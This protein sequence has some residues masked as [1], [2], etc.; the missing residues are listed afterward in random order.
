MRESGR[1]S[2]VITAQDLY[3][4]TKCA[5]RVYLDAHGEASERASVSPFVELLWEMGMQTERDYVTRLTQPYADLSSLDM[6]Q[7]CRRTQ[8]LMRAG[9]GLIY[10]GGLGFEDCLG[11]PDLLVRCDDASSDLGPYHY[12]AIDIKGGHGTTGREGESAGFKKHYAF[13]IL[14]YHRLL[15]SLQGVSP[16]QARIINVDGDYE[17]FDPARF[18]AEFERALEEVRALV[19]GT[20][21][22]EPVLGSVCHLCHW[23]AKCRRWA[24]GVHDP[25]L[26]FGVGRVKFDLK[27]AGLRTVEDIALT[28]VSDYVGGSRKIPRLG[29]DGLRRLKT[30]AGVRLAGVPEIRP[31]FVLPDVRREVYFD[32]E[33]DPTRDFTYLYGW[34]EVEAGAREPL[35]YRYLFSPGA[36]QEEATVTAFWEALA[37]IEDAAIYVYSAKERTSLRRLM[38]RYGLDRS[39]FDRYLAQEYDLYGRLVL[40]YSDW[41][42]YSYGIKHVARYAGF[43]WRDPDPGGANSIVWYNEYQQ[44]PSRHDLLQRILDYNE[45]D[46]RA[47][48]AVK[49]YFAART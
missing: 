25:T 19:E 1:I 34:V 38:E 27:A 39:V 17:S 32:I 6:H 4:Y 23:Y 24:E 43:T 14:F 48:I 26:L 29:R 13:Q 28:E 31:G 12:E 7:A 9:E 45:D 8:E 3:N 36:E 47:M 15:A 11:R 22:S 37:G 21:Q 18:S 49:R 46:C 10:Q 41:P 44:D 35:A 20:G 2:V 42:S 33:D 30:R 40:K 16:R 5:H